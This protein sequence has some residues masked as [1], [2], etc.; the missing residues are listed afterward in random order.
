[1]RS[2]ARIIASSKPAVTFE[3]HPVR[4][5]A[6]A[7]E[8]QLTALMVAMESGNRHHVWFEGGWP[9]L[10]E[11]SADVMSLRDAL[12]TL[13]GIDMIAV[14]MIAAT[15]V[16]ESSL[17]EQLVSAGVVPPDGVIVAKH[18]QLRA[19]LD[20]VLGLGN[21]QFRVYRTAKVDD[22]AERIPPAR[23]FMQATRIKSNRP[24]IDAYIRRLGD[25]RV[26]LHANADLESYELTKAEHD[27]ARRLRDQPL[28][29]RQLVDLGSEP[30]VAH[31]V[32]FALAM[33]GHVRRVSA[34]AP[35]SDPPAPTSQPRP[36]FPALRR[37]TPAPLGD[38]A[39][40]TLPPG[41]SRPP[42]A[43]RVTGTRQR[44]ASQIGMEAYRDAERAVGMKSF[45]AAS[46]SIKKAMTFDPANDTYRVLHAYIEAAKNH[47]PK[48]RSEEALAAIDKI[49]AADEQNAVAHYYRARLLKRLRRAE[50]AR[51]AFA[52]AA[53]LDPTNTHAL[54]ETKKRTT[55]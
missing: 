34:S 3:V 1:M 42:S 49:V 9:V 6:Y 28:T 37:E 21:V 4:A 30:R 27:T 32:V 40:T 18:A 17:A 26:R 25:A 16:T 53:Q 15:A 35:V 39:I 52:R 11:V 51:E 29:V 43:E 12:A 2:A 8:H 50:E 19:R 44:R 48:D 13:P 41:A 23:V 20:F 55:R 45:G 10:V 22:G 14:D 46:M 54:S 36:S 24:M 7:L 47:Y 31:A 5:F 38:P 33:A